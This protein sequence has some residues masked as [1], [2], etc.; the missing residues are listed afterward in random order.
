M[1][2]IIYT[3]GILALLAGAGCNKEGD[4]PNGIKPITPRGEAANQLTAFF[5]SNVRMISLILMPYEYG[6]KDTCIMI[7]SADELPQVD[8]EGNPVEYPDINFNDYTLVIGHWVNTGGKYLVSQSIVSKQD[9]ATINLIIGQSEGIHSLPVIPVFF[10]GLYPKIT[11]R[12]IDM[13]V[14]KHK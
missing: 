7:N 3:L 11:S 6:V 12:T 4:F 10:W 9:E 2:K 13:H 14:I 5:D 8:F 1:K